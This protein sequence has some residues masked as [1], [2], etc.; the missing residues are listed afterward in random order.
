MALSVLLLEI[1]ND[2]EGLRTPA[3]VYLDDICHK[4]TAGSPTLDLAW[5][6]E[7]LLAGLIVHHLVKMKI[8]NIAHE[9]SFQGYF[10]EGR[11]Y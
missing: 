10:F 6:N 9:Y 4:E 7:C 8:Y 5:L 3:D 1:F 11:K 2:N